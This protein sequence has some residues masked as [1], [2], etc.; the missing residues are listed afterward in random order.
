NQPV[1]PSAEARAGCRAPC[2]ACTRSRDPATAG[3]SRRRACCRA[4]MPPPCKPDRPPPPSPRAWGRTL[5]VSRRRLRSR[6]R[7]GLRVLQ[8]VAPGP[9]ELPV[10]AVAGWDEQPDHRAREAQHETRREADTRAIALALGEV[11]PNRSADEPGHEEVERL[12]A[13]LATR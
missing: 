13:D 12:D 8:L 1:R 6:R 2:R 11:R 3:S 7:H 5:L 4:P 9:L 10:R